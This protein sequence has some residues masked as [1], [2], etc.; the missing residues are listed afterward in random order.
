VDGDAHCGEPMKL[1]RIVPKTGM[2]AELHMFKCV[3]CGHVKAQEELT[4]SSNISPDYS[5][6]SPSS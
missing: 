6:N 4:T 5:G 1:V 2:L 3:R